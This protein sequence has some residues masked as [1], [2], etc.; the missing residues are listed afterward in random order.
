M[1]NLLACEVIFRLSKKNH[2]KGGILFRS[3]NVLVLI[4]DSKAD[5]INAIFQLL[6][7]S[8]LQNVGENVRGREFIF[9][10]MDIPYY[11]VAK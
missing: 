4:G 2:K 7:T 6:L 9:D 5:I 8:N 11:G 10:Y 1:E 3:I